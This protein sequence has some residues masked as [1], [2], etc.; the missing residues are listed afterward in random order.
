MK[1]FLTSSCAIVLAITST[2]LAQDQVTP[3]A[4]VTTAQQAEVTKGVFDK[5]VSVTPRVGVV[6]YG[7]GNNN[8]TSRIMEGFT[9]D[10]NLASLVTLPNMWSLG[11]ESGFLYS[12]TGAPGSNFFGSS[13]PIP[14]TTLTGSNSFLVPMYAT[15]GYKPTDK[16]LVSLDVGADMF[17]R[18]IG[19]S[20]TF[21]RAG[22]TSTGSS[23]DFFPGAALNLGWAVSSNVGLSLRGDYIPTPAKDMFTTTLGAT[24]G[25]A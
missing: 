17:Y 21:G 5:N 22:D 23:V 13:A 14:A 16:T 9:A 19:N 6:G 4:P 24:I 12:H 20:I 18:S 11:V 15:F 8:Y 2:A 7:D 1:I 25:I 3:E 10:G